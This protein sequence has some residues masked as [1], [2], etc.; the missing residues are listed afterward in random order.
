[1]NDSALPVIR[2]NV[3]E[4]LERER[5]YTPIQVGGVKPLVVNLV[6]KNRVGDEIGE[7]WLPKWTGTDRDEALRVANELAAE[8]GVKVDVIP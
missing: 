7:S 5:T 8:Y 1:M 3:I 6:V 2:V 4:A